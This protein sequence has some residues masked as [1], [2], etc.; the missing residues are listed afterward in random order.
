M[1]IAAVAMCVISA[2][3]VAGCGMSGKPAV[4]NTVAIESDS[5]VTTFNIPSSTLTAGQTVD[6]VVTVRNTGWKS[7]TVTPSSGASVYITLWKNTGLGWTQIK[8]YPRSA[9]MVMKPWVLKW[10][11]SR[12]FRISVPVEPDWPVGEQIK[13][14]AEVNGLPDRPSMVVQVSR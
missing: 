4:E 14:A 7:I 3:L 12:E 9:E 6:A 10:R 2:F 5:L 13:L 1:R 11:S 8:T